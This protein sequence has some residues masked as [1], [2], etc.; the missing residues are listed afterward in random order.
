MTVLPRVFDICDLTGTIPEGGTATVHNQINDPFPWRVTVG[1]TPWVITHGY[2]AEGTF[3][4]TGSQPG[5][6][7]SL[8]FKP[9]S[10]E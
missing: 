8:V 2:W 10:A 4:V 7:I 1:I 6:T 9:N 5:K 3:Y